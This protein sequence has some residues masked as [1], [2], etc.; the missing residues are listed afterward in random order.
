MV[1]QSPRFFLRMPAGYFDMTEDEQQAAVMAM[2]C[3]AMVQI[4]EDPDKL[5]SAR[6]AQDEN[7]D[8]DH[9]L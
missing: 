6:M 9:E 7:P 2:W 4:G 3:D 5:M 1:E 8:D